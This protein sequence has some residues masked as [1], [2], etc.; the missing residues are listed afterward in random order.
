MI[1]IPATMRAAVLH[2]YQ[3]AAALKIE[4]RPTPQPKPGEVLVK[5]AASPINPSDQMFII[6]GYAFRKPLP[7]VPGFE[8]SGMVVGVGEGVD[9]A[10]WVGRRV[11]C[12]A[13]EGDGAWAEYLATGVPS[14][15]PVIDAITDEQAAMLLVNPLTAWAMMDIARERGLKAIVQTAAAGA[16]GKMI[17]RLGERWG[18]ETINIV[19]REAQVDALR[20]LGAAHVLNSST[21]TFKTDLRA[22]AASSGATLAFDAV[23][24]VMTG[25]VLNALPRGSSVMVY[26][27]LSL[28][29]CSIQLGDI[30]FREKRVEGFYLSHW[31]RGGKT[32]TALAD[33]YA[34]IDQFSAAVRARYPLDAV[35]RALDDY[36]GDMSGGKVL[37][38][39]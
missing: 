37:I 33:I 34:M 36:A 28:E 22:L 5:V 7:V 30:I 11:A 29:A 1:P 16:L 8:A 21:P 23:G 24:G 26:G 17:I 3:G 2:D 4:Q 39:P 35:A 9:A 13:G 15:I 18:I 12:F 14:C 10:A 32:E 31:M 19:R 25:D 20:R 6:G 38:V 27:G